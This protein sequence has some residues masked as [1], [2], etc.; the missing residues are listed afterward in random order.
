MAN[1]FKK[2]ENDSREARQA[3]RDGLP[4]DVQVIG[5]SFSLP[6]GKHH[7]LVAEKNAFASIT[8]ERKADKKVFV[9]PIVA[10]TVTT[11]EDVT[12]TVEATDRVGAKTLVVPA[13]FFLDMQCNGDYDITVEERS[14]RNVITAV[15]PTEFV[16]NVVPAKQVRTSS[17][18]KKKLAF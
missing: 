7:L 18:E 17:N 13:N 15:T 8:I 11:D 1:S 2:M 5:S 4:S 16:E 9:L 10:G 6:V 14:G 12:H 3:W